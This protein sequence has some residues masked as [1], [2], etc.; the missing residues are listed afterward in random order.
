MDDGVP[1]MMETVR[2]QVALA[3]PE[4]VQLAWLGLRLNAEAKDELDRRV[5]ALL[6][7]YKDRPPD[8]DGEP[9]SL[10]VITHP[11]LNPPPR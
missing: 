6:D 9:Y 10:V 11:D 1:I 2:Q 3:D 8:V 4:T 5:T 7:E